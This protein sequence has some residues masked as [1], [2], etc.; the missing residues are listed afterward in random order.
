MP[1]V[2]QKFVR[3]QTFPYHTNIAR[4]TLLTQPLGQFFK[5][6][7]ASGQLWEELQS[8]Q[9]VSADQR[10]HG[11][12]SN[13]SRRDHKKKHTHTHTVIFSCVRAPTHFFL[14]LLRIYGETRLRNS[15]SSERVTLRYRRECGAT[16][17][18]ADTHTYCTL[19]T[20]AYE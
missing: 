14:S 3:S 7:F 13:I 20:S 19:L 15:Y 9:S 11:I 10:V 16:T 5:L 4:S 12:I 6:I 1:A 2:L 18:I 8:S 17:S